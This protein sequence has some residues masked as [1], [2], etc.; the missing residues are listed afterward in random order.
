MLHVDKAAEQMVAQIMCGLRS[1]RLSVGI[2]Q[3]AL[4]E[5]LPF[6]GRAISEW[7]T[8]AIQPTLDHLILLAHALD[9]RL[10]VL[11]WNG[12]LRVDAVRQRPGESLVVFERRRLAWPLKSRRQA[13]GMSQ[14]ELGELVGVSRDS[15]QRWELVRVP[16]RPIAHVVWAQKLG[17]SIALQPIDPAGDAQT[18]ARL[19]GPAVWSSQGSAGGVSF[20]VVRAVRQLVP[21]SCRQGPGF[22]I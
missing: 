11:G 4:A 20:G 17:C 7:E 19:R 14:G 6:R 16:P 18:K 2:S 8:L 21:S 12:L 5:G 10:V 22:R 3:C 1:E 13:M 9:Q 15:I